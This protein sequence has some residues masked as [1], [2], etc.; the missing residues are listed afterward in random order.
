MSTRR[1]V[2]SGL[3]VFYMYRGSGSSSIMLHCHVFTV[4]HKKT[5]ADLRESLFAF[6]ACIAATIQKSETGGVQL[7]AICKLT[8]RCHYI[9]HTGTFWTFNLS[10]S[11][12]KIY[13]FVKLCIFSCTCNITCFSKNICTQFC[14]KPTTKCEFQPKDQVTNTISNCVRDKPGSCDKFSYSCAVSLC[15]KSWETR[16]TCSVSNSFF[17][18][19]IIQFQSPSWKWLIVPP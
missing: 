3:W 18:C 11:Q 10:A 16:E 15:D 14:H 19:S 8:A 6:C 9:L 2:T 4:A 5:K 17:S 12:F 13:T 1:G 7:I